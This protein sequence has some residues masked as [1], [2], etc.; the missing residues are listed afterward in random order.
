MQVVFV[1]C[2]VRQEMKRDTTD[3][4]KSIAKAYAELSVWLAAVRD[5]EHC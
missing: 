5:E 2:F 1:F 3:L 4:E